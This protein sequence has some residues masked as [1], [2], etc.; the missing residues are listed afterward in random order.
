MDWKS[1][2]GQK[3]LAAKY[4]VQTNGSRPVEKTN[5]YLNELIFGNAYSKG[6]IWRKWVDGEWRYFLEQDR[7]KEDDVKSVRIVSKG[8]KPIAEETAAKIRFMRLE[9]HTVREIASALKVGRGTVEK[10]MR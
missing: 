2:E 3:V 4:S 10:Y 7:L 5:E 8:R 9:G 1:E 6:R